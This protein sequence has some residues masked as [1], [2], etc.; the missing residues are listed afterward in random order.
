MKQGGGGDTTVLCA[1]CSFRRG[2]R[3]STPVKEGVIPLVL[4][5][6]TTAFTKLAYAKGYL[7]T[8]HKASLMAYSL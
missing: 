1:I 3:V 4:S 8:P 2:K 6:L 5:L 7:D